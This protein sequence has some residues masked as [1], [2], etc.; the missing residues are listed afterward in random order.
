M[1]ASL[2]G[3]YVLGNGSRTAFLVAFAFTLLIAA[4]GNSEAQQDDIAALNQRVMQLDRAG[5]KAEAIAL[6]ERTVSLSRAQFGAD[7]KNTGILLSQ[8]G[9][10]Y[11]DSGRFGDA[12]NALKTAVAILD[13]GSG[14]NLD[15]AQ[16]INNLGG[17]YLNQELFSEA[18]RLFQR[19]LALYD[20]LPAGKQRNIMRGNGVNNLAVLYG[21]Q[22]NTLAENGQVAEA[23][24]AY[25]RMI[26]MLN[27]VI[28]LWTK[29]F[30]ATNANVSNPLQSRGEAY[31]R[32]NQP[33]KAEADLREALKLRLKFV[34]PKHPA[35][36]TTKN[37]LANVL[38]A[39]RKFPEAEE[40]LL[41]AL[42]VRTETLGPDHPSTARNLNALA[43]LYAATGNAAN[44]VNYSRKATNAVVNH[45]ATETLGVRQQQGAGGLVEQRAAYFVQHVANLYLLRA[46]NATP[47]LGSEALV[48]AQW[49]MQSSTAGAVQQLGTRLASGGDAVAALV[50]ENQDLTARWR[51]R[52]KLLVAAM[53]QPD[54]QQ[55][56]TAIAALRQEV[57]SLEERQKVL[58][59]RLQNEFPDYAALSSPRP[60]NL[61]QAQRLIGDGEA[62][63]VFLPGEKESYVFAVT[64]TD[65]DWRVIPLGRAD[66]ANKV[67]DFRRGLD[68][69]ELNTS[70][71]AG[72]PVLFNL[73]AAHQLYTA[74]LAPVE[75]LIKDKRNLAVV[76]A[77]SLTALPFHL[78]V[79]EKPAAAGSDIKVLG[80]YR[81]AAWLLRRHAVTVLPSVGSLKA[82]RTVAMRTDP[83]KPFV[84]FGDPLFQSG[85]AP[86]GNQRAAGRKAATRGYAD[87]WNARGAVDRGKLAEALPRLEDT[88]IEIRSI[89]TTLGASASDIY[90][91]TA[92]SE[93]Q[94]KRTPLSGYRVVYFATHGLVAGEV[95]GV[96]EPALAL[97]IPSTP[98]PDD[99]GL[100]TASEVAQLK[101]NADWVVLSACN[102]M[103]G[104]VPGAEA[105][106]GLARAFFYAGSRALLVSHWA[107]DSTAATRLT[108]STFD[109]L[110]KDPAIG[111]AEALRRA[112]LAYM[113]D[114][115]EERAAYPAYW[116]PFS[117]VG[118]GVLK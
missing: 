2:H 112:M 24:A 27:E 37:S 101:L 75:T 17:V 38:I 99:D 53:S 82:L 31:A 57:A 62:M 100:L 32:K 67:A 23:N 36:A 64:H 43:T 72:Q 118:E 85:P 66:L 90:L 70:I 40:L 28:L 1:R 42:Q 3:K 96:G 109:I 107:V 105:L 20:R 80:P 39:Q 87:L 46:T 41:G 52:D 83:G 12:E 58:Q 4:T 22:A 92:A 93:T 76:P 91:G 79:T 89:A 54:A 71:A 65:F 111:R 25:D 15:L 18:E 88:A 56:K 49:A 55:N 60:L 81:D 84:G 19:A 113:N 110:T 16:A 26:A 30:G 114:N 48:A 10:L 86:S 74:L 97:T 61:E 102:T 59:T 45:A 9:Y 13:R 104:D 68:V 77:G 14:P 69:V 117:V 116:G 115:S 63:V 11:R 94:V 95:R 7:H 34:A 103:A 106:S 6:A 21:N 78:L 35:I 47:D 44:A 8:L 108:T 98:T 33:D 50:R 5:Q 51:E 29:E 73:D